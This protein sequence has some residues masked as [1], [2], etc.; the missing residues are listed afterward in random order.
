MLASVSAV[1]F[2]PSLG[3][4]STISSSTV[5]LGKDLSG[6]WCGGKEQPERVSQTVELETCSSAEEKDQAGAVEDQ[7][8][9][10]GWGQGSIWGGTGTGQKQPDQR[11]I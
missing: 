8:E 11:E 6:E 1:A 4:K 3:S 2:P 7:A 10:D 9:E 5:R